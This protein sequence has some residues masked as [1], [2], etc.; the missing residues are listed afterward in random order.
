M[1]QPKQPWIRAIALGIIEHEGRIFVAR[2]Y[3]TVKQEEFYRALG[4]GIDFGETSDMTLK[5]EFQE[6]VQATVTNLQYLG[7]VE[8]LFTYQG[9]PG[10]E[11]IQFYRCAF[12]DPQFYQRDEVIGD[13][14]GQRF[15]ATWVACDRFKSGELT[16]YPAECL[17]Y[18]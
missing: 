9:Q 18:L 12:A 17:A 5:R 14:G 7:C 1:N 8:N 3:D 15:V 2:G 4:G 10:H 13:E 11:I 16:L 6:E